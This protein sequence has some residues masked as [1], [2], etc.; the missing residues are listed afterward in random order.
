VEVSFYNVARSLT[1]VFNVVLTFLILKETTSLATISCLGAV[2]VGF[3]VG[4]A[5]EVRFS[6]I[7]T[8]FGVVSSLF[9]SLNSIYTKKTMSLVD[10]NQWRLSAYNNVNA[11]ILFLPLIVLT[12]E[13]S[14][15]AKNSHLLFS[16]YFWFIMVIGGVFGFLIGIVTIMQIKVTSPL[17]H[18]I[19]GTAKASVQTVLAFWIWQNPTTFQ[20]ILGIVLVLAGSLAYVYVRTKEMEAAVVVS[21]AKSGPGAAL[22]PQSNGS[23]SSSRNLSE[24]N[25]Q[26]DDDDE[27]EGLVKETGKL[28]ISG[29]S[30]R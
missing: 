12:G 5:G 27:E 4:S 7:G 23:D 18:N 6:L 20:N 15:I 30:H 13:V 2:V 21:A 1:I 26:V 24:V 9:V 25:K 29:P 22:P 3:F 19:S 11:C 16:S 17:T 10:G 28:L 14:V 8:I